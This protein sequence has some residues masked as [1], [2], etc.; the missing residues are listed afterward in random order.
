MTSANVTAEIAPGPEPVATLLLDYL[1][2]LPANTLPSTRIRPGSFQA[3][4]RAGR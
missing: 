4:A 3:A 2:A 1:Q